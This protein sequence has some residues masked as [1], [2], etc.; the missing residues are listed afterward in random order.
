M[1]DRPWLDAATRAD[2]A[3]ELARASECQ[4]EVL[5]LT[6]DGLRQ[7]PSGADPFPFTPRNEFT[8]FHEEW[9]SIAELGVE[10]W[11]VEWDG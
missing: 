5:V 8:L 6:V 9:T 3:E 11:P 7:W 4:R 2:V 1:T 10:S